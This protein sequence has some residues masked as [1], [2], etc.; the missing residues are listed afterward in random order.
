MSKTFN[1]IFCE[2]GK[3]IPREEALEYMK[4]IQEKII[5]IGLISTTQ[6]GHSYSDSIKLSLLS[7]LVNSSQLSQNSLPQSISVFL[8]S[9]VKE[10]FNSKIFVLDINIS[11]NKHLF[12]L[13]FLIC[14]LF[15]FC[16]DE[17]LNKKELNKFNVIN[18]LL[19]TLKFKNKNYEQKL[20]L[21]SESSPKLICFIPN[22]KKSFSDFYLEEVLSKKENEEE[23]NL[24]KI[25]LS[26][27]FPK[28]ELFS[29]NDEKNENLIEK[30]LEKVNPKEINGKLFD[31]NALAFFIQ[32]FC[33]MHNNKVNPD[34]DLLFGNLIYNDLQTF[35]KKSLKYYEDNIRK[36]EI[37][38]EE[39]L[40]PKIYDIKLKAIE[41]YNY[42]QSLNY[43]VFN[44]IEYKEYKSSFLTI[45]KELENKFTEL[46]NKKILANLKNSE[47]MCNEILEKH[48]ETIHNKIINDEYDKDNT[49]EFM[50]DYKQFLNAYEKEAKGNN[51]IKCLIN[52]L[53]INKPKYFKSIIYNK[54]RRKIE[55]KDTFDKNED[56]EEMRI[57]LNR[58]KRE[59]D[60]LK[61]DIKKIEEDIKK[62]QSLEI[63]AASK[64]FQSIPNS[65]V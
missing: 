25:N 22:S 20:K 13:C 50:E 24:L 15:V 5:L 63:D 43:K 7:N 3:L 2:N 46:E 48:Y 55:S 57:K 44:K 60:N 61:N 52:F 40:I 34:F 29:E 59:I 19:D 45:K 31:G 17:N 27:F 28:R 8:T 51:K 18:S 47:V 41:M 21:F 33:E 36:L 14:S 26:R 23:I 38:N 56:I 12:S 9:L 10:N 35:K 32:Q 11:N 37:E 65:N 49:D 62:A 39:I 58:K 6:E 64:Q 54:K 4:S 53:E 16:F 1:L 42:V 30:I